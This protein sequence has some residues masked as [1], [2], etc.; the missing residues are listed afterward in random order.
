MTQIP[1]WSGGPVSPPTGRA[2]PGTTIGGRYSLRSPVGNG[3]MGTV[4]RATDTLLRRD[5]AVKE[6]VLP[7]GLAPSDRDAMYERTLREARAAAAIQHPA[8]VQVYDVVTEG[9]RPWIVMEL[10]DARS[11]ADMVIEDG[12]VA[13][14][15]VAKIGI[16]LLGALEVAHAIGVLHRDVK[17]ANVLICTDGRC[18]LTDFGVARMPTDVQLTTPG[19]VLGSPHFISPERA[20]GQDFG[21]PSDL[22]SLGVTLYTAVE[23]RPP[24]DKGDPIETMHAVVEDPPAPPQR[25]GALTR[26]LMGLL[27]KDPARRMDVHTARAMLRELLAGPLTSNATAVNSVTDPYAVVPVQRPATP[28]AI[29]TPEP[30]PTGQIGGRAMIAPGESLTDRLAALRR[31]ER[32]E[33]PAVPAAAALDETSADALASPLDTPTGAMPAPTAAPEATQRI[34]PDATQRLAAGHPDATQRLGGAH[35]DATQPVYGHGAAAIQPGGAHPDATQPVYGRGADATQPVYG[36]GADATQPVYAGAQWSVPG[37]GQPWPTAPAPAPADGGALG[38]ARSLGNQLVDTVKGWPRKVQ[39]GVAGGVAVLLLITVIALN[40]GGD[41]PQPPIVN[42]LPTAG[43][44][45]P[46]VEMQEQSIKGVT[47]QVPKGWERKDSGGVYVDFVDPQQ[48]G[49]KVRVLAETWKGDSMS[50]AKSAS[51]NLKKKAPDS[52]TCS[53]PYTEVSVTEQELAGKP[54]AEFEYTC[55]EGDSMRHGVWRGVVQ[56]GKVYSF[57]LTSND[58]DFAESKPIFDAMVRSFQFSGSN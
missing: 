20:M 24:F 45:A 27:E 53:E 32:P 55:G 37:T 25:S 5:V 16:A 8:V 54:A 4:W 38:K 44:E 26:V 17:P 23:G 57:Y 13:P 46:P 41:E 9:G 47:V 11:L 29:I 10:L 15:A 19:M 39:L 31:G 3:G 42:S 50:W 56:G 21:P 22:F 49:R 40:S 51:R 48:E 35:P 33:P 34:S 6:V 58:A 28:P 52:K 36:H 1:T 18:V 12:P 30:K 43:A 14:R 2:A 7:P